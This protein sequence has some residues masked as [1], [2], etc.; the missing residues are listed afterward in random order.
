VAQGSRIIIEASGLRAAHFTVGQLGV[1]RIVGDEVNAILGDREPTHRRHPN[2]TF[3]DGHH[4]PGLPPKPYSLA[5][6]G[7]ASIWNSGE[8]V[9]NEITK[10]EARPLT[11]VELDAVTGGL[12]NAWLDWIADYFYLVKMEAH[13][14]VIEC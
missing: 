3:R 7:D 2:Q 1:L 12:A 8:N 14:T 4:S 13:P 9:M 5:Y 11:D 10:D 6:I